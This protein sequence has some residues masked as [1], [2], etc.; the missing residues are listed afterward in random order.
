MNGLVQDVRYALRQLRK[1]PGFTAVSVLTLTLGI[2]ANTGIFTLVNAVLLKSLPV[3]NPEEIFVLRQTDR[4]AERT[5]VSYP[6]F[7]RMRDA[8]PASASVAA[9]GWPFRAFASTGS[10]Q[11]ERASGQLVSGDYFQT[12]GIYPALGRLLNRDD[13]RVMGGSPVALISYGYWAR[14]FALDPAIVGRKLVVNGAPLTIVG[15]TARDFFGTMAGAAPDFWLPTVMQHDVHYSE[16]YS[17]N[18]GDASQPWASQEGVR[19]VQV[20]VRVKNPQAHG[21]VAAALNQVFH[22]DLEHDAPKVADPQER[23]EFLRQ[24]VELESSSRGLATLRRQFSQPLLVLMGMVGMVL[25]IACTNIANLLLARATAREREIA[26]RLS[27]GATRARLVRQLLTECGLLALSGA[28][29]GA[30]FAIWCSSV[31]PKWASAESTPIPLN[32]APDVRVLLFTSTIAFITGV[33][34][35]MAP[36]ILG[37][38]V[39]VVAALKANARGVSER[40]HHGRRWSL[41]QILVASQVAL[42]LLLLIGSGLFIRTLRNFSQ[43]DP[44]FERDHLLSVELDLHVRNYTKTEMSAVYDRLVQRVQAIPGVRSAT[45]STC[46]LAA[47]CLDASDIYFAGSMRLSATPQVYRVSLGYFQNIGVR[48]LQG[49]D[50]ISADNEKSPKVAIVNQTFAHRFLQNQQVLGAQFGYESG[51]AHDREFEIVG[52]VDDARVNDIREGAP[53]M[54][55]MPLAQWIGNVESLDVR[56]AADPVWLVGQVRQAVKEVDPDLP[57]VRASTLSTQV[58]NNLAQQRLIVRLTTIFGALALGLACLGLYGV[59]SYTVARRTSELGIRMAL[60][61]TRGGILR[62]MLR[63]TLAVIAAGILGGV[64]LSLASTRAVSTLLFG[65]SSHDPVTFAATSA[66]LSAVSLTAGLVPAWRATK[67]DPVV[68]LRYE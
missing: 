44:G 63:E 55:Y 19:W 59:M 23:Q 53:P 47:G 16:H 17:S 1:N 57:V 36:A 38:R 45:L 25:L 11:P 35:G 42:S 6:L 27:M 56:T 34:F 31:L 9:M 2:G 37:T 22:Q 26:V 32:L 43:L 60:G 28:A 40:G 65:L 61:S 58:E 33:L 15:V 52:V 24:R 66:L 18:G 68:A 62:M 30:A 46:G 50:F 29:L 21:Q 54:L 12:L 5:R 64:L 67:V 49:R 51:P 7:Q 48:L 39:E 13:D 41:R 14:H 20:L 3:P 10:E 8:V 4:L